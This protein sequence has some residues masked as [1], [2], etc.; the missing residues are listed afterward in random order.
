MD[1]SKAY[2]R[3]RWDFLVI[4]LRKYG[5]PEHWISLCSQCFST[6]SYKVLINGNTSETFKPKCGLRQGDLLSPY[7][8]L[9]CMDI[10][11]RMLIIEEDINLF[12]GEQLNLSKSFVKFS[13]STS[14]QDKL[15]FKNI[16]RM[17][18]MENLDTH[19][20]VPIDLKGNKSSNFL[21]VV[22]KIAMRIMAWNSCKLSFSSKIILANTVLISMATHVMNSFK[23]PK[24]IV[25]K[26]ESLIYNFL[27]GNKGNKGIQ[28][29][30]KSIVQLH[31]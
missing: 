19:L 4:V 5:F 28:W 8:F 20:G 14:N 10:L 9:F 11:S 7:L 22:D 16:L 17:R 30:R 29:V 23:L 6:V 18:D 3:V 26:I 24:S 25:S 21:Y 1:M 15:A 31:Y 2:D 12:K 13:S 27:W